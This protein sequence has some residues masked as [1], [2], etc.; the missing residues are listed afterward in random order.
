MI[1]QM[2]KTSEL[3]HLLFIKSLVARTY[4]DKKNVY[5]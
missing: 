4:D 2:T 3:I 1:Y 5:F